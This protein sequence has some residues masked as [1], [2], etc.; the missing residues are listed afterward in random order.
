MEFFVGLTSLASKC[1]LFRTR[2]IRYF[3]TLFAAL[4]AQAVAPAL[5]AQ[6]SVVQLD[7]AHTQIEFTL[8]DILHTVHGTFQLKSG[9][10]RFDPS[11]GKASGSIVVDAAS[12]ESGNSGRDRKMHRE[13]LES[14]NFPEIDFT[15][16]QV[17][18]TL[19]T[20]GPS[21]V[22]VSGQFRL[23][24]QDH[25]MTVPMEIRTNGQQFQV[26]ARIIV[27]YVQWG[28]KNPSTLILRV[29]DK[30][31]IDIHATAFLQTR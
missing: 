17:K 11:T 12:G 25:D 14:S 31:T 8:G 24:G 26:T 1:T 23:H 6:E 20:K 22:E 4:A 5:H 10:I 28:L 29:S 19:A 21:Q 16:N 27:P 13:I 15:P 3:L 2:G 30:V 9:T 18:G 7:A